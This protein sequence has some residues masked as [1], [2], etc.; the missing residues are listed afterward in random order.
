MMECSI[1]IDGGRG[2]ITWNVKLFCSPLQRRIVMPP[3][4]IFLSPRPPSLLYPLTP[5]PCCHMHILWK[6]A[7]IAF[8][9]SIEMDKTFCSPLCTL[10]CFVV[11]LFPPPPDIF[12]YF[13]RHH[14]DDIHMQKRGA[15]ID[16]EM[17]WTLNKVFHIIWNMLEQIILQFSSLIQAPLRAALLPDCT[18]PHTGQIKKPS[19]QKQFSFHWEIANVLCFKLRY[20]IKL[21][22]WRVFFFFSIASQ[23]KCNIF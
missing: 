19:K 13:L 16:Y 18:D 4:K 20:Q 6:I 9:P 22:M 8:A 2:E 17:C 10:I 7:N 14:T 12:D 21:Q 5:S 15:D 3:T 11:L 1:I 23:L